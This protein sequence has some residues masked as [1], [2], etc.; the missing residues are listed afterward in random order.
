MRIYKQI[1]KPSKDA[2]EKE[3]KNWYVDV[4][5][6]GRRHRMGLFKSKELSQQFASRLSVLLAQY[7]AG[8]GFERD[9]QQ[10]LTQISPTMLSK[11]VKLGLVSPAKAETGKPIAIHLTDYLTYLLDGKGN[12][13]AYCKLCN[14]RINN[15]INGCRF[16]KLADINHSIV[17]QYVNGELTAGRLSQSSFNHYLRQFKGFLRWLYREDRIHNDLS[18]YIQ[19]RT[20]TQPAQERRALTVD[21][22]SCL[23]DWLKTKGPKRRSLTGWER[24]VLYKLA[25]TTGLR[26]N[27][28]RSLKCSSIDFE[29]KAIHLSSAYTKNRQNATLP[30]TG[31]ILKDLESLASKR[32]KDALLFRL[33][34]KTAKLIQSDMTDARAEW[35]KA[36]VTS[37]EKKQRKKTDFLKPETGDGIADFHSL[38]HTYATLLVNGGTDVKTAQNLLR[39]STPVLTLGIYSHVLRESEQAAVNKLPTF[40][41]ENKSSIR[42][43]A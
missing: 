39:H 12:S 6:D 24:A 14:T 31:S 18:K 19:L 34:D 26:A 36:A 33:T 30:L 40:E 3:S 41:P 22:I 17:Q 20:V 37:A 42:K 11:L 43:Q 23:L 10:W 38:R 13:K 9:V 5:F 21:E 2:A 35:I 25:L 28:I 7:E 27:E 8:N 4:R 16:R 15:I 29:E 32:D 1:F